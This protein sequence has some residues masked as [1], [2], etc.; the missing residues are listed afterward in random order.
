MKRL[1]WL[2]VLLSLCFSLLPAPL[3]GQNGCPTIRI[4]TI[5]P[6]SGPV[7]T[8]VSYTGELNVT[9]SQ[10]SIF[11]DTLEDGLLLANGT[12]QSYDISGS[13]TIPE[14]PYG[15][16]FI[17]LFGHK[18]QNACRSQEFKVTPTLTPNPN[19]APPGTEVKLTGNGFP[20]DQDIEI[21]FDAAVLET[22]NTDSNGVF[23]ATITIPVTFCDNHP[24]SATNAKVDKAD[25]PKVDFSVVPKIAVEGTAPTIGS[26]VK[27]CGEGFAAQSQ[28]TIKYDDSVIKPKEEEVT[29]D[30]KGSFQATIVIPNSPKTS[31]TLSVSDASGGTASGNMATTILEL[32]KEP[33][34]LPMPITPTNQ[35]F[36]IYGAKVVAF[37]WSDVQDP[38]GVTYTF[39]VAKD[40]T[41]F[42]PVIKRKELK[43]SNYTLA[44]NEALPQG[45]YYWRVKATDG[46]GNESQWSV[47]PYPIKIGLFPLYGFAILGF[48]ALIIVIYIIRAILRFLVALFRYY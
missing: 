20:A 7:G 23:T 4:T 9:D 3:F 12:S 30:D 42:P 11:W 41:F 28:I 34:P 48:L 33:P 15:K 26:E 46:A 25:I 47:S 38:S 40:L 43:E 18:T 45:T 22:A 21:T 44:P 13:F 32:E 2:I 36:G 39:E 6:K 19:S 35:R 16:H 29:T 27:V 17:W 14:A 37:D 10:Y 31:H 5:T 24:I 1:F 8:E